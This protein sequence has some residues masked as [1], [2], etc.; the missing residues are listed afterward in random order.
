MAAERTSCVLLFVD[1]AGLLP[2]RLVLWVSAVFT[3]GTDFHT[4]APV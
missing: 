3:N 1:C 2:G 4:L